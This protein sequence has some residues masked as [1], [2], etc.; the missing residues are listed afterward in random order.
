[1]ILGLSTPGTRRAGDCDGHDDDSPGISLPPGGEYTPRAAGP[2]IAMRGRRQR[3][4]GRCTA[5]EPVPVT[6]AGVPAGDP[7]SGDEMAM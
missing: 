7:A 6:R 2:R 1:M 5:P 3:R 4:A